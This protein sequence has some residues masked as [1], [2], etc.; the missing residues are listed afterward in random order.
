MQRRTLA[1]GPTAQCSMQ[2]PSLDPAQP[3]T[4]HSPSRR[5]AWLACTRLRALQGAQLH[6]QASALTIGQPPKRLG[7][8]TLIP[9]MISSLSEDAVSDYDGWR[10]FVDVVTGD[11]RQESNA[12]HFKIIRPAK[13]RQTPWYLDV[14]VFSE[15]D[16]ETS[17]QSQ[18]SA[19]SRTLR[20]TGGRE[21]VR[22]CSDGSC[23]HPT[24]WRHSVYPTLAWPRA[25]RHETREKSVNYG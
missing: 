6:M 20:S 3:S 24:E 22:R 4:L 14:S 19:C 10:C 18:P 11:G 15:G 13:S 9:V 23:S 16:R 25:S 17:Q 2:S 7:Q 5:S 21:I 12:R 1:H 8:A